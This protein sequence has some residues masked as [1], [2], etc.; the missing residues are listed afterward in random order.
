[1]GVRM[2]FLIPIFQ[3]LMTFLVTQVYKSPKTGLRLKSYHDDSDVDAKTKQKAVS[4]ALWE[5]KLTAFEDRSKFSEKI[6]L[7]PAVGLE[8]TTQWL[9]ATC[10]A[11]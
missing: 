4:V 11:S 2:L 1:M 5:Q 6:F 7:A 9:T 10:S 8:P 3:L